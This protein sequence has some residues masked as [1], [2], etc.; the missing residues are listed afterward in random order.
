MSGCGTS[1][2]EDDAMMRRF[3]PVLLVLACAT[4]ASAEWTRDQRT[5]FIR[6]C[7]EGCQ[8]TPDLSAAGRATC[9]KA[10]DCLADQGEKMM[11]PADFDE[12]D[13]AAEQDKMTPKL[14][15]LSKY[16]PACARQAAG[17]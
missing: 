6:S 13:K 10:C 4:S 8:G 17:R 1:R 5:R 9:P 7:V 2:F 3:L 12:A 11:T 16:F 15:A 14:E